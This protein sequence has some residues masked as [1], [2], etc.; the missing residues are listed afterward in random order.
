M[1][2]KEILEQIEGLPTEEQVLIFEGIHELERKKSKARY[3]DNKTFEEIADK[4]LDGH[5]SV[6]E[7]LA[8]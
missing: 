6:M 4:T 8:Q 3:A 5:A 1:T 2:A 7:K